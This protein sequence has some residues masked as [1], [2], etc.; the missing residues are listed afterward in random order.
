MTIP[1]QTPN[2]GLNFG[3]ETGDDNWGG[4]VNWNWLLLDVVNVPFAKSITQTTPPTSPE[5]GDRYIIPAGATGA[6]AN[7][8][9]RI[10]YYASNQWLYFQ[11]KKGWY[12]RVWDTRKTYV[13]NGTAWEYYLDSITPEMMSQINAAVAA[14]EDAVEAAA[15]TAADRAA[16]HQ[17]RV[18]VDAARQ[19]VD[20][21]AAQVASD[22]S[23]AVSARV[24]AVAAANDAAV[25]RQNASES[26]VIASQRA[27]EATASA[28]AASASASNAS[29]SAGVA[30]AARD[31]VIPA[32]NAYFN[33]YY[34]PLASDPT[35]R[36]DGSAL[37]KGDEYYSTT[38]NKR[39]V[40]NGSAWEW[41]NGVSDLDLSA[42]DGSAL[43]SF[44]QEGAGAKPRTGESKLRDALNVLDFDVKWDGTT[45]DTD[46]FNKAA[47]EAKR[48]GRVLML[49]PGTGVLR[50]FPIYNGVTY[51]G[52]G[53][54]SKTV[55]GIGTRVKMKAGTNPTT[56]FV[57]KADNKASGWAIKDMVIDGNKAENSSGDTIYIEAAADGVSIG[58]ENDEFCWLENLWVMNG[59]NHN[60][61]FTGAGTVAGKYYNPRGV[62]ISSVAS[63]RAN[64]RGLNAS[65]LTDS[66]IDNLILFLNAGGAVNADLC[67]NNYWTRVKGFYNGSALT[68]S[69]ESF[70][71][72][73]NSRSQYDVEAQ[74]EYHGGILFDTCA[75]ID[76]DVFADAN[77]YPSGS[78]VWGVQIKN[79]D[80]SDIRIRADS[81]HA[82]DA[83][84]FKQ[85]QALY[86]Y[87]NI[88]TAFLNITV[89]YRNQNVAPYYEIVAGKAVNAMT[90][91][92][93]G[94]LRLF[95][96]TAGSTG[97]AQQYIGLKPGS[98]Q[99]TSLRH[100]L[101]GS[102]SDNFY[103]DVE[104]GAATAKSINLFRNTNSSG[105]VF[106][107]IFQGDGTS[108]ATHRFNGNG[109][110]NAELCLTGGGYNNGH[111]TLG[112]A[113]LWIDAS[114]RLRIKATGGAPTSDTDGVVVG[115]QS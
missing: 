88:D 51:Q 85:N 71:F 113:H 108:T 74:E 109:S 90:V 6:W 104:G 43:F 91:R 45:D 102:D 114:G 31:E 8:V 59:P 32:K 27:Q 86:L 24:A 28:S 23:A 73:N 81:F 68:G 103:V 58:G 54:G 44:L 39:K 50:Y 21:N 62:R 67:A 65:R 20:T 112:A 79:T 14:G 33:R 63:L 11:P 4:P 93:N 36:P 17:D 80:A 66:F 55:S 70:V 40:W 38:D 10:A 76:A 13:W 3:W 97:V 26:A 12:Q 7:K 96:S 48:L 61:T 111:V 2:V 41:F 69:Q 30:T 77:G 64:G 92:E 60:I 57:V 107:N 35:T 83:T 82:T 42:S 22:K 53:I 106:F 49:P 5:N 78:A 29:S 52:A 75:Q 101:G 100:I 19:A 56:G 15:S 47:Q 99:R 98:T 95:S 46:N 18:A 16:V 115:T 37:Q 110:K 72:S 89:N 34:G 94:V 1:E 25:S 87:Q 84:P 9:G 105:N